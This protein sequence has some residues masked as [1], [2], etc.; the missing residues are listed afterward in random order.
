MEIVTSIASCYKKKKKIC[1]EFEEYN[2][3]TE[4]NIVSLFSF[5]DIYIY[6][7]SYG[8]LK[9]LL[10]LLDTCYVATSMMSLLLMW[11]CIKH[12]LMLKT[13]FPMWRM[14]RPLMVCQVNFS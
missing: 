11:K 12:L 8:I 9:T 3:K 10:K 4:Y 2:S 6:T 7:R 14:I 1:L 5:S 13:F